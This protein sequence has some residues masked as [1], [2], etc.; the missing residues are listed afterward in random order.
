MNLSLRLTVAIPIQQRIHSQLTL[1]SDL[2]Y[3]FVC[4]LILDANLIV[5]YFFYLYI[6]RVKDMKYSRIKIRLTS[7][8]DR[9]YSEIEVQYH[10]P[11][12]SMEVIGIDKGN[13]ST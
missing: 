6:I 8:K 11:H 12:R 7:E 5:P 9:Q 1:N 10:C 2:E 4:L 3:S 13:Q